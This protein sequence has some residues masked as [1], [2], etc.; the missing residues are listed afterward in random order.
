MFIVTIIAPPGGL[1]IWSQLTAVRLLVL[2]IYSYKISKFLCHES[3]AQKT[4][5]TFGIIELEH[6][7]L[8]F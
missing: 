6:N 1:D 5:S 7:L 2:I 8:S 3:N 4:V